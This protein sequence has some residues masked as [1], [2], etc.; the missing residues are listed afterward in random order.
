MVKKSNHF[1]TLIFSL[2]G[3]TRLLFFH[4]NIL[5]HFNSIFEPFDYFFSLFFNSKFLVPFLLRAIRLRVL[6]IL[7]I[8]VMGLLSY[9]NVGKLAPDSFVLVDEP[10]EATVMAL[11]SVDLS[12]KVTLDI[13]LVS[14][15]PGVLMALRALRPTGIGKE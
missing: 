8:E 13:N 7:K 2:W 9:F 11:R 3:F 10:Q 1:K 12:T 6:G 14:F 15:L 4:L 5:I